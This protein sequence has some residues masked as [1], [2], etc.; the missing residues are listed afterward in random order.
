VKTLFV[1]TAALTLFLGVAWLF[2]P[3]AMLASWNVEAGQSIVY[4][5]RRYGA[6]LFG[7]VAILWLARNAVASPA[8]TAILVGGLAVT[9]LMS[10]VSLLGL[11]AGVIGPVAWSAVAI[12]AGLAVAF[13]YFLVTGR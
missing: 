5:S 2:F 3:E 4:M 12:E 10:V 13:L 1:A 11:T 7:Y 9:A 6:L 8:R